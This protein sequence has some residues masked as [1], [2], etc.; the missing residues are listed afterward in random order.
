[1]MFL[2]VLEF[3]KCLWE[4]IG[5][6]SDYNNRCD[7]WSVHVCS[8]KPKNAAGRSEC[9]YADVLDEVNKWEE[10]YMWQYCGYCDNH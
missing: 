6:F 10:W 8:V 3:I 9:A 5:L 1:M 2:S 4:L 7:W